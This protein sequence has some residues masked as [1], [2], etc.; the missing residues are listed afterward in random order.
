[1]RRGNIRALRVFLLP[2]L[3]EGLM[4]RDGG[5]GWSWLVG[6]ERKEGVVS[7][8]EPEVGGERVCI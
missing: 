2:A 6:V 8:V 3:V 4:W 7:K 5:H 1:M